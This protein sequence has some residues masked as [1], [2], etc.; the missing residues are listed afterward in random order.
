[1]RRR[2]SGEARHL[3]RR[4]EDDE[5]LAP[6]MGGGRSQQAATTVAPE[7]LADGLC[8]WPLPARR[9]EF[10][11]SE[12]GK[13]AV[14]GQVGDLVN[15][16]ADPPGVARQPRDW[17]NA[18]LRVV[19]IP[20]GPSGGLSV[21]EIVATDDCAGLPASVGGIRCPEEGIPAAPDDPPPDPG[22]RSP[23]GGDPAPRQA[24]GPQENES[25]S[26]SVTSFET[27]P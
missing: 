18:D 11:D 16:D 25:F 26:S 5:N 23:L 9:Q 24:P 15:V 22:R 4:P 7:C 8:C 12:S 3:L 10:V 2:H 1:M 20:L 13:N 6:D 17:R 14:V 19:A 27:S 21:G